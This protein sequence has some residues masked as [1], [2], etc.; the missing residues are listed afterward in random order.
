M[1][2]SA[3]DTSVQ[4][5]PV[6]D[7]GARAVQTR[8]TLA[9]FALATGGFAIGT[10]EFA[11]MGLLSDVVEDLQI[12]LAMGGHLISAYAL[13]VVVGAPLLAVLGARMPRKKLALGL[14]LLFT[15]AN[16]SSY[17]APDYG[18]LLFTRFISGLP[19]GAYFGLAAIIAASL[20]PPTRRARAVASVMLGLS[21]AN[22]IG[23]PLATWIGQQFGWRL[24]FVFVG[25][26]GLLTLVLVTKYV[27]FQHA[28]ADASIR[29]ELGALKR[30]QVWLAL[31]IGIVGFGGFFA[32]YSYISPTM[33]QVTGLPST[34]LP[35]IVALYGIGMVVGNIIGGRIADRSV[36]GSIYGCMIA[37]ATVLLVFSWAV[38]I[39]WSAILLVF[40]V[41]A[42]GSMLVPALQ[43]RLMDVAGDAQSLAASLNHAALNTANALGAFLG[44][45]VITWGWGLVAP[46]RVGAVLAVLGL[47][48]A[49]FSGRLK[50]RQRVSSDAA[51]FVE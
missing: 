37:V 11:I 48:I 5:S 9:I 34:A 16:L 23:V 19:H 10:T 13:G 27:P 14:I 31:L 46:A 47:L 20:V 39:P 51:A 30:I 41:G 44:G 6:A 50:N 35:F 4:P 49:L 38:R 36:M 45:L 40:L 26:I 8:M 29:R 7:A 18:W 42:A 2:S 22:V 24:M 43:T 3:R 1:P 17:V 12:S 32:V 21:I 33:T 15:L 28:A 25:L